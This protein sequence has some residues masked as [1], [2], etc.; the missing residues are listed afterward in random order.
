V[1][2]GQQLGAQVVV[3]VGG[4]ALALALGD[5]LDLQL[6]Q[7]AEVALDL[8]RGFAHA[9][10]QLRLAGFGLLQRAAMLLHQAQ[11]HQHQHQRHVASR[12]SWAASGGVPCCWAHQPRPR[13]PSAGHAQQRGHQPERHRAVAPLPVQ[14]EGAAASHLQ[15]QQHRPGAWPAGTAVLGRAASSVSG[16]SRAC[17]GSARVDHAVAPRA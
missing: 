13:R 3:Q 4:D 6:R 2:D 14:V 10:F 16:I 12:A 9:L 5:L 17:A 15:R 8:G 11:A 7:L 1:H